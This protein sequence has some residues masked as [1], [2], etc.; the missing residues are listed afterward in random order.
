MAAVK[1][2]E[3]LAQRRVVPAKP[4]PAGLLRLSWLDRYPTQLALIESLHVNRDIRSPTKRKPDLD[5]ATRGGDVSTEGQAETIERA[6]ARA[7]VHYYPL[8]GSLVLSEAGTQQTVDCSGA[9]VWF[10]EAVAP[11]SLEEVECLEAPLM[12]PKNELLPPAPT[13]E[14]ER[15]LA[16]L[17]Q[18]TSFA[19]GVFAVGF[20]SS[21]AV[22]IGVGAA[23]RGAVGGGLSV[24]P[25]WGRDATDTL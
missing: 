24:T 5:C 7:L 22:T 17:I 12:I 11:C 23:Q 8:A 25:Q 13:H 4:T 15:R 20:R 10:T 2:I 9:D 3:R 1:S 19:C 6:L 14:D 16:L 21:H 18:V